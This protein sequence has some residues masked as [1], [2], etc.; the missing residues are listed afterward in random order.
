VIAALGVLALVAFGVVLAQ[1]WSRAQGSRTNLRIVVSSAHSL[2]T[3]TLRCD[4]AGGSVPN[5]TEGCRELAAFSDRWLPS[6]AAVC[7]TSGLPPGAPSSPTIR[8]T[9]VY[10]ERRVSTA[11]V[12]GCGEPLAFAGWWGILHL[13]PL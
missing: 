12:A 10:R 4:P 5:P 13:P 9:G 3:Y 8:V 11:F 6:P 7:V 1:P 2:R